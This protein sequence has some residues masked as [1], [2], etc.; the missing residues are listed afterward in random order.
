[1]QLEN[2]K[3]IKVNLSGSIVIGSN[4][5]VDG[6][7]YEDEKLHVITHMHSDHVN[8]NH[9]S[10]TLSKRDTRVALTKPTADLLEYTNLNIRHNHRIHPIK[11]EDSV[12][13]ETAGNTKIRFL[14]ADHML[15]S[16]QVEVMDPKLSESIGYSGDIG[17]NV[18]KVLDVDLLILDSTYSKFEDS[19][20]YTIRDAYNEVSELIGGY[21]KKG[22][23]VNI[24]ATSG[25]LQSVLH[26]LSL[27]LD[28]WSKHPIVLTGS[29]TLDSERKIKH[30]CQ[31]YKDY[32]YEQPEVL[33][34]LDDDDDTWSLQLDNSRVGVFDS[35]E[36]I[37]NNE[38][39]TFIFKYNP[40]SKDEP[41]IESRRLPNG[42]HVAI[43]EHA[44]GSDLKTYIDRV[45]PKAVI[46]D[47]SRSQRLG[48]DKSEE[49][50]DNITKT[51]SIPAISSKNL[52]RNEYT[53]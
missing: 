21:L 1:M 26:N 43:T 9:I 46:T 3:Y 27:R 13:F 16:T 34:I 2:L 28:M 20:N 29:M 17:P 22:E 52:L 18:E 45:R 11:Y 50:A 38:N 4:T 32:G 40:S 7:I 33:S 42:F 8:D 5:V 25:L 14:D 35:V 31:I 24:V 23:G 15:G 30:L 44:T 53:I 36:H 37:Q 48:N 49:L 6:P 47:A 39:P 41:I 10:N 51:F 19:R 12:T